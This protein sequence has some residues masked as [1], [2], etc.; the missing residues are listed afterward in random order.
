[1]ETLLRF[2]VVEIDSKIFFAGK[3]R[4]KL[5]YTVRSISLLA[6][7]VLFNGKTVTRSVP[8]IF[9]Q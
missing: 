1:M 3:K 6:Y 9:W 4:K 8:E 2:E 5:K 7:P